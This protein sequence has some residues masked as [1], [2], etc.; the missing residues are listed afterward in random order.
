MINNLRLK[1]KFETV[2]FHPNLTGNLSA[3]AAR[4]VRLGLSSYTP[5]RKYFLFAPLRITKTKIYQSF[6]NTKRVSTYIHHTNN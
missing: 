1:K 6:P 3:A 5:P 2:F 4:E